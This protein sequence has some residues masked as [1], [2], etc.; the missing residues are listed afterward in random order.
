VDDVGK[1]VPVGDVLGI[2]GAHHHSMPELDVAAL[3]DGLAA[4][5]QEHNCKEHQ[6]CGDEDGIVA[7]QR[8]HNP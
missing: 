6:Q 1:G 5:E 4:H 8:S 3:A 2:F 7:P